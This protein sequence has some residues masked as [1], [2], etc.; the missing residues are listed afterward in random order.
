MSSLDYLDLCRLCLVK[1]RVSVPIFEGEGDVRQIFLKIAACLPVKVAREDKLPKKICD[2]CVYK[3]ELFYQFWNTTANAEKQL[4]Q[5]LGEVSLEDK[6]GYVTNVLNPNVMKQEQNSENRLDGNV[7]QQVSEHQNNMGMGMMDNMGLGIP[8]IISNANQQIT[9][10]PMDTNSNNVQTV[11]AVPGPSSQST[12]N[13]I[14]Q[15]Q[16]TSAQQEDED[17]SSEDDENSDEDCDGDEGLPVKEESEEDPSNRTIEPTTFVNVSLACDEA[18]PSG[19]QQQKMSDMPEIPIPQPTDGDPKSGNTTMTKRP[20]PLNP[21]Q[22]LVIFCRRIP[23]KTIVNRVPLNPKL[24]PALVQSSRKCKKI[25]QNSNESKRVTDSLTD[26]TTRNEINVDLISNG[27]IVNNSIWLNPVDNDSSSTEK[28][29]D[30]T[31]SGKTRE[32]TKL[33][34]VKQVS[35]P[36]RDPVTNEIRNTLVPIEYADTSGLNVIKNILI[37]IYNKNSFI[38]YDLKKVVVPIMRESN[39]NQTPGDGNKV[40]NIVHPAEN[41]RNKSTPTTSKDSENEIKLPEDNEKP[42]VRVTSIEN[43]VRCMEDENEAEKDQTELTDGE[44]KQRKEELEETESFKVPD[45]ETQKEEMDRILEN[46]KTICPVCQKVFKSEIMLQRH[47]SRFHEKVHP[48]DKCNKWYPSKLLLQ[49]HKISHEDDSYLQCSMCHLKYKRKIGLKYH[50]IRMHSNIEPKYMCDHCGRR[51]K[52]KID[53]GGHIEK[54]HLNVSHICKICG[55]VVKNIT[56]HEWQH[57]R[58]AKKIVYKY[59]CNLCRKKFTTHNNLD[60]HLLMH[61]DGFKCT[62]CDEVFS[63][64]YS[65]SSHKST[66]HRRGA[67][68]TI[69]ERSFSSTSNF[70]QHVLTHAGIRP[71]KCDVCG[72]YFTQRSSVLRHRKIHPGPLPPFTETTSIA[73]IAKNILQKLSNV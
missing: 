54:T 1:D 2:D 9:S 65:L 26:N 53:L 27:S 67:T 58:V 16:T 56:H 19:L 39:S 57:D 48:C 73:D 23:D 37:P 52:L 4:L 63:S 6:Q 17:E 55:K 59:S 32:D 7:M 45:P 11:Q 70:Y 29:N 64:P 46:L 43:K 40:I 15:N 44:M 38:S 66:K 20:K 50:H 31:D 62:L 25:V 10:V 3:V 47:I 68:C 42:V 71:Y 14:P 21:M 12:H 72:D 18:G 61:K 5:W 22:Q 24:Y 33:D 60:N 41:V 30:T 34:S 69:C 36:V 28:N 13:Q 49:E 8:M 51:F 35:V